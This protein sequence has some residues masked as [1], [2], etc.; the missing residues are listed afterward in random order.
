MSPFRI[1]RRRPTSDIRHDRRGLSWL[2]LLL[3]VTTTEA[4]DSNIII[5]RWGQA[6]VL[7]SSPPTLVIQGG[8]TDPSSSYTYSN[9][10]NT[11]E[12]LILPLTSNFSTTSS[13]FSIFDTPSAPTS[14]WHTLSP[15]GQ[16]G[17][18]WQLLSFGGDGGTSEAVQTAADSA[19]TIALDPTSPSVNFTHQPTL[20][21][22]EPLRRIYHAAATGSDDKTYFSGGLKDDGSG[23]TF[24]D[25]HVFD[26]TTSSFSSLPSL[27]MGL[28]H[29]TSLV[30]SN[31]TLLALGGA[32][33]SPT[34]GSAA[35]QPYS[36]IYS[37]DMTATTPSWIEI[38]ISGSVPGGRRGAAAT[39]SG[40]GS[41]AFLFGGANAGLNQAYGDGWEFNLG[42]CTWKQVTSGGQGAG[43]RFDHSAVPVGGDQVVVFG[44]YGDGQPADS[45][46]HIWN[47]ASNSW[48]SSFTPASSTATTTTFPSAPASSSSE[49]S[50][51]SSTSGPSK[52]LSLE[53]HSTHV[54][55]TDQS[56]SAATS[57]TSTADAGAHS[58]PLTTPI[59]VGLVLGILGLLAAVF[60]LCLWHCLRRRRR[61]SRQQATT[62]IPSW[63]STGPKGRISSRPYGAGEKSGQGWIQELVVGKSPTAEYSAWMSREK[64]ASIG[65]GMGVIGA[66][67]ASIS[68]KLVPRQ[69]SV[70]EDPYAQLGEEAQEDGHVG[71]PLRKSTRRVG[72]GIRLVGPR[73]PRNNTRYY[74]P[75]HAGKSTAGRPVRT[76]SILRDDRI[77]VFGEEEDSRAFIDFRDPA[78]DDWVMP[79]DESESRWRS[80]KSF[81]LINGEQVHGDD[82][83]T[84]DD[85]DED[86]DAPILP[87]FRGGPVPTPHD[88][89]SDLGTF[90]EIASMSNPYS[91]L[92]RISRKRLSVSSQSHSIEHQLPT[93]S[94]SEPLD[95]AGL[96]VPPAGFQRYSDK[97]LPRSER[98]GA[99]ASLSDAEEG[100]I[101]QARLARQQ[102][103]AVVS[104]VEEAYVPIKRSE[105]F[106]RRMAAGGITSL[107]GRGNSQLSAIKNHPEI[108][109][110]APQPTLWPVISMEDASPASP[111][112]PSSRADNLGAPSAHPK[113]PS[114]SSLTSVRTMR[115]MVVI[116]REITDSSTETI[117]VIDPSDSSSQPASP[118]STGPWSMGEG[119]DSGREGVEAE[120]HDVLSPLM[121]ESSSASGRPV[122][123]GHHRHGR[124]LGTE[125]PGTVIFN[126][127][128]FASPAVSSFGPSRL[129]PSS[130]SEVTV[131]ST[132]TTP[133]PTIS[134]TAL[135]HISPTTPKRT[136][137]TSLTTTAI[138]RPSEPPSGSP[139]PSPLVQHRRPVREV[140]NSINKRAGSTPLPTTLLSPMSSYSPIP[141]PGRTLSMNRTEGSNTPARTGYRASTSRTDD[142]FATPKPTTESAQDPFASPAQAFAPKSK[143]LTASERLV[144]P[145]SGGKRIS[146]PSGQTRP[147][148]MWQAI[149]REQELKVANPDETRR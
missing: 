5:P 91:E 140:V 28:Y 123:G 89:R 110:P 76:A 148:T 79:S 54:E 142:P 41:K 92:S 143:T 138:E 74:S 141:S 84:G 13:P 3:T 117:P 32:Y 109:D 40:D 139:V 86:D 77:D 75:M 101:H 93:L 34:T 2:L 20:W 39:L 48:V 147:T 51:V 45:K 108:R 43:P 53:S 68:S 19:W 44:G 69:Q 81:F 122:G 66:T 125:T 71:G 126:G 11:G 124:T 70:V 26:P 80:A 12:T 127:A 36:K 10:P 30:L 90:D 49:S 31:G 46:V 132:S 50:A 135:R 103:P 17:G 15:I 33:T 72:N 114:L 47:S 18:S 144:S 38:S 52:T 111:T 37:I 62:G 21:G 94:P 8:K 120:N 24:T 57:E 99:S 97:S 119:D 107:L 121:S 100:V 78:E 4:S 85:E 105:S 35:L 23:A 67:L 104:P 106:F 27:P 56:S 58:H 6:A 149:K 7:I 73:P 131:P 88:S 64:G 82:P 63:P 134:K 129:D 9:S 116:Q 14:S 146:S 128:D 102:S 113:G 96:L 42:D 87:P 83:F 16:A 65:L 115:D 59:R 133:G 60:G 29:H 55:I 145:A 137:S 25:V 1:R 136:T 112:W 22:S 130:P 95:L 61:R 118:S 98:S